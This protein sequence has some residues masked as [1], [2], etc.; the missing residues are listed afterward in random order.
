MNFNSQAMHVEHPPSYTDRLIAYIE[1][2]GVS[3]DIVNSSVAL[4][5]SFRHQVAEDY[6]AKQPEKKDSNPRLMNYG[7]YK[8][9]TIDDVAV[10]DKPYLV[11]ISRQ[12][13][14]S[15]YPEHLNAIKSLIE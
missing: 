6:K 11:W 8:G 10:F 2:S 12:S 13:S 3:S 5:R 4:I 7:K 9:R 15:R 14:M 1:S